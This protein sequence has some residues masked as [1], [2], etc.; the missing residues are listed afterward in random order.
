MKNPLPEHPRL[1]F[2]PETEATVPPAGLIEHIKDSWWVTHPEHG[3]AFWDKRSKSPQCNTN[4]SITRHLAKIYPWAEI[5]FIP[6]A[7][8]RI[9]PSDYCD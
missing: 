5:K 7:Y 4:E 1:Y 2:V 8:R 9:N 6:S 3:L